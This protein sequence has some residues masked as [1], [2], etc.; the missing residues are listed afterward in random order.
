MVRWHVHD[1][2]ARA[3][4]H[5]WAISG[6]SCEGPGCRCVGERS[7]RSQ[8]CRV[9]VQPAAQRCVSRGERSHDYRGRR[10]LNDRSNRTGPTLTRGSRG[11]S[12]RSHDYP[13]W[14]GYSDPSNRIGAP[15]ACGSHVPSKRSDDYPGWRDRS[16]R[17]NPTGTTLARGSRVRS[18][19]SRGGGQDLRKAHERSQLDPFGADLI[20]QDRQKRTAHPVRRAK[21]NPPSATKSAGVELC[22]LF[23]RQRMIR[24]S[25][26]G[27]NDEG[28]ERDR[29]G[30]FGRLAGLPR[31]TLN[32]GW[33]PAAGERLPGTSGGRVLSLL[34]NNSAS[35]QNASEVHPG[36][37]ARDEG[38]PPGVTRMK[39]PLN[40]IIVTMAMAGKRRRGPPTTRVGP[41]G[42]CWSPG[43]GPAATGPRPIGR[44]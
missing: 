22:R 21:M 6:R 28:G 11:P 10:D 32:R 39:N 24:S 41:V 16:D 17:S 35:R 26:G 42:W 13:G 33:Q 9:G 38:T 4:H 18:K 29:K 44:N 14:R 23:L 31:Q 34:V 43:E 25:A 5:S 27:R 30:G 20:L 8:R 12:K 1:P 37:A 40:L 3:L 2:P 19:R 15:L 7:E 36:Q